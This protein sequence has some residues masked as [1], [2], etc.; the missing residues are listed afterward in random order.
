MVYNVEKSRGVEMKRLQSYYEQLQFPLKVVVFSTLLIAVGSTILHPSIVSF[1]Q[2]ESTNIINFAKMFLYSGGIILSYFPLYAF[3]KL[4]LNRKDEQNILVMGI[5]SLFIFLIVTAFMSGPQ[6]PDSAYL[7]IDDIILRNSDRGLYR[8]GILP[9]LIAYFIVTRVYLYTG[10]SKRHNVFSYIDRDSIRL[11]YV[12]LFSSLAAILTAYFWPMFMDFFYKFIAFIASDVNN[13]MSMFAYGGFERISKLLNL[14][15]IIHQ[16]IWFSPMGGSWVDLK[17]E[18]FSGDVN[19]WNA[20]MLENINVIGSSD[21]GRFTSA[22][23]ILNL[24][25]IPGYLFGIYSIYTNEKFL[26]RNIIVFILILIVSVFSGLLYP[27]EI[28]MLVT[29]PLL[30]VFHL[31]MVSFTFAVLSGMSIYL[32]FSYH[33]VLS[34]ANPGNLIDLFIMSR[35]PVLSTKVIIVIL[36]GLFS[37]ILYFLMTRVYYSKLALDL[38]NIGNK[39]DKIQD[40]I[41]RLGGIENVEEIANTPTRVYVSLHDREKLNVEGMHRQG[42]TRIAETKQGF[43]LSMGSSSY[44]YQDE[45]NKVLGAYQEMKQDDVKDE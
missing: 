18:T 40:F 30:Y 39:Q 29:S 26:R 7:Q 28:L 5:I 43:I 37:F 12:V 11:L 27:M 6:L 3:V 20:Q 31:F 9:Y 32:G 16:E 33:G 4:L 35:N 1:F 24:F 34:A 23:Y 2:I 10:E 14:D 42:V 44:I 8:M 45:T 36:L 19:I 13:P 38:L 17:G 21:A 22:Y 15:Q 25:S 41:E